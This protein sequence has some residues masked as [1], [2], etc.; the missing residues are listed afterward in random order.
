MTDAYRH[1]QQGQRHLK[2]GLSAQATVA[3]EKAKRDEPRKASIREALGLAYYRIHR[4][5]EA[6][7]EFRVVLEL[8]PTDH[9]AH[10]VLGRCLERKSK[11]TEARAHYKL[12]VSLHPGNDDYASALEKVEARAAA[13]DASS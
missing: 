13:D 8:E 3:L 11:F 6:E 1:F 7:E 12:A 5:A 2:D 10:F 9:Y 4:F